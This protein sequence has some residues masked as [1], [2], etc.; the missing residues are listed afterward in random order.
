[1]KNFLHLENTEI[2]E[3]YKTVYSPTSS[4]KPSQTHEQSQFCMPFRTSYY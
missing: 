4:Y 2:H 1:M 3:K